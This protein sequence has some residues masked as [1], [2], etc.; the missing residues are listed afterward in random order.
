VCDFCLNIKVGH[1]VVTPNVGAREC[2]IRVVNTPVRWVKDDPHSLHL[3]RGVSP[4]TRVEI[5]PDRAEIMTL[6]RAG[7]VF[8]TTEAQRNF[9]LNHIQTKAGVIAPSA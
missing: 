5:P 7:S 9:F 6:A 4:G 2:I 1:A 3:Q 8:P